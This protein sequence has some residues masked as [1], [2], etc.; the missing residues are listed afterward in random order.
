MLKFYLKHHAPEWTHLAGATLGERHIAHLFDLI[1]AAG[2]KDL[3]GRPVALSFEGFE[4]ATA[5]YIKATV[6]E[7][8]FKAGA[9][10][11]GSDLS[12]EP[13]QHFFPVV[14]DLNAELQH[15]IHEVFSARRLV[16]LEATEISEDSIESATLLG[17]PDAHLLQTLDALQELKQAT[18][19]DL[20]AHV[21][22]TIS[23]TGWNNRL[24]DLYR[25]R[26]VRRF[27]KDRQWVYELV[28][29]RVDTQ[30]ALSIT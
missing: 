24:Y 28:A 5:S 7:L 11:V 26:L 15:G 12:G 21:Q 20:K 22:S 4:F 1:D 27:K 18:A 6:L 14:C 9:K 16:C 3:P 17:F 19:S 25:L 23:T 13:S 10:A 29:R 2:F 30:A 8:Y